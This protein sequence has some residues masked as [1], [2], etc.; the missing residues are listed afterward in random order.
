MSSAPYDFLRKIHHKLFRSWMPT[1][2]T[3]YIGVLSDYIDTVSMIKFV[4]VGSNDG[5]TGDPLFAFIT[6]NKVKG[7]L[8]EPV[9]YLFE[10]LKDN[11]SGVPGISF[12]NVAISDKNGHCDFFV[13]EQNSTKD[14]PPWYDQLSSFSLETILKHKN[15]IPE[16]EELIVRKSMP[17]KTLTTVLYEHDLFDLDILHID[18][19][20]FDFEII[21]TIDFEQ[22]KPKILLF[23]HKHLELSDYKRCLQLLRKHFTV[24]ESNGKG[25][26]ICYNKIK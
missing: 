26:T 16:L 10:K 21:K 18:T 22:V 15:E 24:V 8:I 11:Y 13:V 25:D 20:G 4:Q 17:T 9:E 14:L 2:N 5:K 23:E 3:N 1:V 19:E 6:K 12:E 7:V